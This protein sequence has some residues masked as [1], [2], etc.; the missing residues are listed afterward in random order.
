MLHHQPRAI[1]AVNCGILVL[2]RVLRAQAARLSAG[3]AVRTEMPVVLVT[4]VLKQ[5]SAGQR[6]MGSLMQM[7]ALLLPLVTHKLAKLAGLTLAAAAVSAPRCLALK[8]A[9]FP[10]VAPS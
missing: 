5:L 3:V 7:V 6:V 1:S 2:V 4:F 8:S 9:R 10:C